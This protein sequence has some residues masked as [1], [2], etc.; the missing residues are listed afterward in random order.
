MAETTI[1]L[2]FWY[3]FPV[4]PGTHEQTG[5]CPDTRQAAF[6][7]QTPGHGSRHFW[8]MHACVDWHSLFVVH[9]G[10]HPRLLCGSP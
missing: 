2:Q 4:Y 10:P 6:I 3:G 9:S 1:G 8:L 5:L 7:P